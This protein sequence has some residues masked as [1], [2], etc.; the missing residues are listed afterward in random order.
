MNQELNESYSVAELKT[1]HFG[2][3]DLREGGRKLCSSHLSRTQAHAKKR[4][5]LSVKG[6]PDSGELEEW[7]VRKLGPAGFLL[8]NPKN[9]SSKKKKSKPKQEVLPQPTEE[10]VGPGPEEIQNSRMELRAVKRAD[11]KARLSKILKR[12]EQLSSAT[13][14]AT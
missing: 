4:E 6:K 9:K 14:D 1:G 2:V 5:L 3:F 7:T 12:K 8:L 13:G 11:R 10:M